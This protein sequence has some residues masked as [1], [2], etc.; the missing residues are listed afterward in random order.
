MN[1]MNE[2]GVSNYWL[3]CL[4][5]DEDAM[6]KQ[7]R[8]EREALYIAEHSKSCPTEILETLA[9]Y[10]AEGRSIWKLMHMQPMFKKLGNI[11][12][13]NGKNLLI[14]IKNQPKIRRYFNDFFAA[15]ISN[16]G[17]PI[18]DVMYMQ[19]MQHDED[20]MMIDLQAAR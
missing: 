6:C 2:N 14:P 13:S 5:I 19:S 7:V 11:N 9:K 17:S 4:I 12:E 3:S 18:Y 16:E 10:N 20:C 8:S 15:S 1:P